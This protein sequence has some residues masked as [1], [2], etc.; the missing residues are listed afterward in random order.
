MYIVQAVVRFLNQVQLHLFVGGLMSYLRYLC[1]FAYSGI[2]H[3][4]CC[5]VC[6]ARVRLVCP[7]LPVS[8]DCLFLIVPSVFSNVYF[9]LFD[10]VDV[11]W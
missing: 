9:L 8:V 3:I 7:M 6:C 10:M 2:Q 1:L 11:P 4:L 5:V